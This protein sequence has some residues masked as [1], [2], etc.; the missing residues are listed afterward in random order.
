[1]SNIELI[2]DKNLDCS[3]AIFKDVNLTL[4]S[5]SILK[6]FKLAYKTFGSLN[7][8]KS[9]AILVYHALTGDQY[10]SGHIQLQERMVGGQEWL[11]Q[12]N[13]LIQIGFLLF[14]LMC[15]VAV[16]VQQAQKKQK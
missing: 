10:V 11:A 15:L 8:N 9:N 12:I 13:Q 2:N 16:Q 5:G 4:E 6:N 7:N 3:F 14:V 1:M